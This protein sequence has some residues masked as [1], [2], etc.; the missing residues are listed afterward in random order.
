MNIAL[1]VCE[2]FRVV[3]GKNKRVYYLQFKY[4]FVYKLC[5][6]KRVGFFFRVTSSLPPEVFLNNAIIIFDSHILIRKT[7]ISKRSLLPV[8]ESRF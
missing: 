4:I 3:S 2:I 6:S 1:Q 8:K 7:T 5:S